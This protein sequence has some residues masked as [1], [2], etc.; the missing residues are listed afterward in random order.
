[1]TKKGPVSETQDVQLDKAIRGCLVLG[2]FPLLEPEG[3]FSIHVEDGSGKRNRID[4]FATDLGWW[5]TT[6]RTGKR[7]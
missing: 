5:F 2:V 4:I 3:A 7:G 6:R 1:M